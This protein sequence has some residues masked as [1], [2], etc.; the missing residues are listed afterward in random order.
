MGTR[1]YYRVT[2]VDAAGN[3]SGRS[4]TVSGVHLDETPPSAV[5][6]LTATPTGYGFHLTW[7]ANPTPDLARYVVY[8]G[9]LLGDDEEKVCSVHQVEWLGT[10][11]TSY[12]YATLPDGEERCL[13]V[14]AVDEHWNSHYE[15]TRSP[16]HRGRDRAGHHPERADPGRL[17]GRRDRLRREGC[18]RPELEH[19]A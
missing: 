14:D 8:A 5:T 11:T 10:D 19:R 18:R 3:E 9:Q 2:A 7:D 16:P 13:F 12:D 6:G 15:W 1:Y 17:T 4:D